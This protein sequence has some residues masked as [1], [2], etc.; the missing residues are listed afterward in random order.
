MAYRI[1]RTMFET[2]GLPDH[3]RDHCQK[4]DEVWAEYEHAVDMLWMLFVQFH[5]SSRTVRCVT[6]LS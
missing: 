1:G 5:D 2:S 6:K 4:M 3:L